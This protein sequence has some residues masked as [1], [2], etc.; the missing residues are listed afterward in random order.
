[1]Q[2][3]VPSSVDRADSADVAA[4][5][6]LAGS[7]LGVASEAAAYEWSEVRRWLPDLLVGVVCITAGAYSMVRV[8]PNVATP[9]SVR[10]AP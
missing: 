7:V 10:L 1:V 9:R 5:V 2:R 6:V 3:S 8:R 4:V